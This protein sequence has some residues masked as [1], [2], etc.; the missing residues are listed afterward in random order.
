MAVLSVPIVYDAGAGNFWAT[1]PVVIRATTTGGAIQM[2]R[3]CYVLH[4]TNPGADPRPG[5]ELWKLNRAAISA[6]PIT[7]T[8]ASLLANLNCDPVNIPPSP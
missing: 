5:A 1:V 7:A 2:F 8:P 6:A 3:G 4:H